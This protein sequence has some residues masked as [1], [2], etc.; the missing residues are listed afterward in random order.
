MNRKKSHLK[1]ALILLLLCGTLLLSS[2]N[3][4]ENLLVRVLLDEGGDIL[5]ELTENDQWDDDW[6]DQW[7]EY[8]S[9]NYNPGTNNNTPVQTP[10]D[11]ALT[12][13][14]IDVGQGD[15]ILVSQGGQHMLIDVGPDSA[16]NAVV[17]Y[18]TAAGITKLDYVVFTH[19]HEDHIGQAKE[20]LSAFPADVAYISP[21]TH[22]TAAY[23]DMLEAIE[24]CNAQLIIAQ[25]GQSFNLGSALVQVYGPVKEYEDLNACSVIMRVDY[26]ET[27]ALFTGDA[28]FESEEDVIATGVDMDID[29]LKVGHHG[30]R[31][32][33]GNEL[34]GASTPDLALISC[35]LDN[36]YGHPHEQ[37]VNRLLRHGATIYRTDTQGAL[38]AVSDGTS[39]VINTEY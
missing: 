31:Y 5:D 21:A 17:E 10:V 8:P 15:S 27:S 6:Y 26:G 20:V 13:T 16:G 30:S 25:P 18:L 4:I 38:T 11:G 2:C 14:C 3:M 23:E 7:D 36:D 35:G 29:L 1:L 32:A 28:E 9:Q 19:P 33:S 37:A 24:D 22:T 34:L 39:F 12:V